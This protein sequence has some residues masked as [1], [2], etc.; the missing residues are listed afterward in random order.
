M[1]CVRVYPARA[2][3]MFPMSTALCHPSGLTLRAFQHKVA[4]LQS[5]HQQLPSRLSTTRVSQGCQP[6]GV[7]STAPNQVTE[8]R[9]AVRSVG[10]AADITNDYGLLS[11]EEH[12]K[13]VIAFKKKTDSWLTIFAFYASLAAVSWFYYGQAHTLHWLHVR[14]HKLGALGCTVLITCVTFGVQH[15]KDRLQALWQKQQSRAAAIDLIPAMV[16]DVADIKQD[17]ADIR[18]KL[19]SRFWFR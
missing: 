4:A 14:L 9:F 15:G 10:T 5:T 2:A 12:D 3:F 17:V 8:A 11:Q 18:N 19:R 16:D 1:Q 6:G 13:K 7:F